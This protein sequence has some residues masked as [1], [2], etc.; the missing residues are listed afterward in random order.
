[1][2][3]NIVFIYSITVICNKGKMTEPK[4][5]DKPFLEISTTFGC[6]K[7]NKY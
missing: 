1:M 3:L 4:D 6:Q 7:N 5:K 2:L